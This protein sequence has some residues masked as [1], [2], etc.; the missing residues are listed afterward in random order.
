MLLSSPDPSAAAFAHDICM[1]CLCCRHP[2]ATCPALSRHAQSRPA[3]FPYQRACA[4]ASRRTRKVTDITAEHI[5]IGPGAKPPLFFSG[6]CLLQPGDEILIPDPVRESYAE[7]QKTR[8][9]G[10]GSQQ[11][12]GTNTCSLP[13]APPSIS[14]NAPPPC[15][16]P[17]PMR[18]PPLNTAEPSVSQKASHTAI[19]VS[20]AE[21]CVRGGGGGGRA[22][23]RTRRWRWP[24]AVPTGPPRTIACC[25][26][27]SIVRRH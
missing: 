17:V 7:E 14:K 16:A 8:G 23:R 13:S 20:A 6:Q 3:P 2:V 12:A 11:L 25:S 5:V 22:S 10:S 15:A 4:C 1:S 26:A 9:G 24:A 19:H 21:P 18:C 27:P